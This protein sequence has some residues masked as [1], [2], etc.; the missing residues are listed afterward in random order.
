MPSLPWSP[1]APHWPECC[2]CA[3]ASSLDHSASCGALLEALRATGGVS[4]AEHEILC[5]LLRVHERLTQGYAPE[6]DAALARKETASA[7]AMIVN[8][9]DPR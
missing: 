4:V 9:L 7:L 6:R 3:R 8:L 1:P 5:R 2:D